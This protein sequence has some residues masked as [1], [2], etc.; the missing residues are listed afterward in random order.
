MRS[1]SRGCAWPQVA[2]AALL[3][4]ALRKPLR[5]TV[6]GGQRVAIDWRLPSVAAAWVFLKFAGP[7]CGIMLSKVAMYSE[8]TLQSICT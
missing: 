7:I 4:L 8:C 1:A 6:A 5:G 3:L 2:T